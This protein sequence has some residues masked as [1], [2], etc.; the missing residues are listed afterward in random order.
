MKA[1]LDILKDLKVLNWTGPRDLTIADLQFDSRKVGANSCFIAVRGTRVD[2]HT[3]LEQTLAQGAVALVVEDPVDAPAGVAVIQVEDTA[4]ALGEM[5]A[6]WYGNPSEQLQVV[7]ITGTN[8]KTST[9]T[10]LYRLLMEMGYKTG[11]LSTVENRIGI[12]VIPAT[13]T[14]PDP[15]QLQGLLA[16]M[17]EAGCDYAFMEASSHAID[18]KRIAGMRFA[19]AVFTNLSHD[20]LD[21]HG[22]FKEY[23][24]AKKR[25]FDN[26]EKEAFALVNVDDKRGEVM[27]QNTAA[28]TYKYGLRKA[29]NFRAKVLENNLNGLLLELDG[30]EVHTPL[31]GKFNAYNLLAAYATS[32]LLE[33]DRMECLTVLSSL[34][35]PPG[36]FERISGKQDGPVGIVDYAH[37]P[38]ALE[39][40]LETIRDV[41]AGGGAILTVV[42]CGGDRDKTKRPE[43]A[44]IACDLSN[45]V[46]LTSDNPRS[47]DPLDILMDMQAGV[48]ADQQSKV[49]QIQDRLQAIRTAV[50][51]AAEQDVILIAGK[52]HENYQEIKGI[53][54]PFDDRKEL[55]EALNEK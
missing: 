35:A 44:R 22:S 37:T 27:L 12:A 15:I 46:I 50:A 7:G 24:F 21:Y 25:L 19:G 33:L 6:N 10:L 40:V 29:A 32:Q 38:D 2:G 26:L 39:K 41:R 9:A 49:L 43:M 53:R 55:Q 1:L 28:R 11:L 17:V 42:G 20:H 3:F 45:R 18:Q 31:V 16:E 14:T 34:D 30:Q 47:E 5:A 4:Q 36:R 48:R 54:H 8:G 51:L 52:G 23:I 13:H